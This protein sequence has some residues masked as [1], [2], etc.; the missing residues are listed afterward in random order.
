MLIPG[1]DTSARVRRMTGLLAFA[2]ALVMAVGAYAFTASNEI[3][4]HKA[5]AGSAAVSGYKVTEILHYTWEGN[6]EKMVSVEFKI[7]AAASSVKVALSPGVPVT[8]DWSGACEE[9][10]SPEQ[11]KCTFPKAVADGEGDKLSVAAVSQG[12]VTI[13]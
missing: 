8:A 3:S 1:R 9:K 13:E 2:L 6:G 12:E 4:A 10:G 11:W 5:G 7:N